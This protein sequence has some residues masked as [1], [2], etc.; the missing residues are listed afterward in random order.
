MKRAPHR[1]DFAQHPLAPIA[2]AFSLGILGATFSTPK[3]LALLIPLGILTA[4]TIVSLL[5]KRLRLAGVF[6]LVA[7]FFAGASLTVLEKRDDPQRVKNLIN[8]NV[9]KADE[10]VELTGVLDG[11]PEFAR[12]R[13][14]FVLRVESIKTSTQLIRSSGVISLQA[15]F[16]QS[17][18][19]SVYRKLDLHHASRVKV[20]TRLGR[21]DQYRNPGISTLSEYLEEKGYDAVGIVNNA[22]LI[23]RINHAEGPSL[24]SCIYRWRENLQNNIDSVF[25]IETAGI[26]D[27][28]LLGNRHNLSHA[29]AERFREGGTFHVLV[30][31]GAHISFI[32]ALILLLMRRLTVRRWL[33]LGSA[34]LMVWCYAVAVGADTS[35]VRAALMFSFLALGALLF[36]RTAPLN[37]LGAA[38][39][40]L[41]VWSP[42]DIFDPAFQLTFLSVLAIVVLAWPILHN[43]S[44][45]GKWRPSRQSP[46]PPACST[47]RSFS[48]ALYWSEEEWQQ[49]LQRLSHNCRLFKSP[50]SLWLERHHLQRGLRYTFA[51]IV[52]SISVQVV[53]L[54]LQVVYFHRLSFSSLI[55]TLLVG[56]LLAALAAVAL[57]ALLLSQING[58]VAEPLVKMADALDWLMIHSVDPF[59][60]FGL[61]SMRLAEYSEWA[62]SIYGLYY[63]PLVLIAV[64]LSRW[65]PLE[66][67]TN[68]PGFKN[69]FL[70]LLCVQLGMFLLLVV[71][72]KSARTYD[73]RLELS[74]LDVGQGDS[75][76]VTMPDGTTLLIDG[77][78]RP[79]FRGGAELGERE[80]RSIGERVV[81]EYLWSR[82]L[83][84]IDYVLATHSDADHIDGLNDVVRN[85][86]VRSAIV[87]RTPADDTAYE[88]F[89]M[90]LKG[91]QTPIQ[92]V[93]TGDVLRFGA[94]EIDVLWPPAANSNT[95][96]R[97]N[98]S[99]VLRVSFGERKFLLTGDIE[100]ATE[101]LLINPDLVRAEVVKVPHHGSKS[102]SSPGFVLAVR[103]SLAII[104]VG[105]TSMFGH[106]HKEVVERWQAIG[107]EVV[108]TGQSGMI[109]VT[110]NGQDL[111]VTKFV[112]E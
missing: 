65:K 33:Q 42:G 2:T 27:A 66:F 10:V 86:R 68:G 89:T 69:R 38:A 106:P 45:I 73:G 98:D 17:D 50:A 85:F 74:F 22:R 70:I 14:I 104:S 111:A 9:I 75:V 100:K 58:S 77:G 29:T 41:L 35:V 93:Q 11:Q 54:P 16:R 13:V 12:D 52:V 51:A 3:L 47:L 99:V 44:E 18:E 92:I 31:S 43:L 80:Q 57:V 6:L 59:A 79:N 61:A 60:G 34:T 46:H 102:S 26:L 90:T 32:G 20:Q 97:N 109:T 4:F 87:G 55:L 15:W 25:S 103:P 71:H 39:L 8:R 78:G 84:S 53:L 56:I 49:E 64:A 1:S 95:P 105:Q 23:V 67:P 101:E 108:T 62:R 5:N 72:P 81:C 48:E 112:R 37:S 36:R 7:F 76:L 28:A 21:T 94:V 63:L 110:T 19:Q 91:Q 107:A 24:L 83:D 82:G 30:I 40:V 88:K 96:S